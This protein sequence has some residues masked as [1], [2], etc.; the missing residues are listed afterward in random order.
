M[1][2]ILHAIVSLF[3]EN[4]WI[5]QGHLSVSAMISSKGHKSWIDLSIQLR[6]KSEDRGEPRSISPPSTWID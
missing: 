3:D 6:E 2:I 4:G 5:L 1:L